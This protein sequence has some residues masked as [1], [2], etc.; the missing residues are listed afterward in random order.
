MSTI[1]AALGALLSVSAS[2][3]V[4]TLDGPPVAAS[5]VDPDVILIGFTGQPGEPAVGANLDVAGYTETDRESYD[6]TCI[7]S[8]WRGDTGMQTVRARVFAI[9]D[10]L[11]AA[12]DGDPTLGGAVTR[13]RL[14]VA[15]VSLDQ[16]NEGAAATVQF[17]IHVDAFVG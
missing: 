16:I 11:A 14:T 5:Q 15:A 17:T 1:P 10:D 2:T 7:A 8:S 6:V 13:A 3:G 9:L 12:L 4:Q